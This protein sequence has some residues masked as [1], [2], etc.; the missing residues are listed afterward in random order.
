MS[1]HPNPT[2][3]M[4][5]MDKQIDATLRLF[6]H[7][8]PPA[9]LEQRIH[10]RLHRKSAQAHKN[11]AARLGDFFFG[12]RIAFVSAAAALAC[13]AIVMSSVQ[14][15]HQR[16]IPATGVHLSAPGSGL[17]AA[18]STHIAPQP[19]VAPEHARARSERKAAG[20]RATVSREAHKP[21][22]V[23]VPESTQ[24]EKP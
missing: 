18:S 7:A 24:P 8:Q 20:G 11:V 15:S 5:K 13:V 16:T 12:Q 21:K 10:T 22:G 1:T 23:A 6:A 19:I 17:G 9:G 2:N 3:P 4:D 14:H